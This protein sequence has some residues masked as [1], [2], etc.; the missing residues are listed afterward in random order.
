MPSDPQKANGEVN[1]TYTF[2]GW[3]NPGTTVIGDMEFVAVYK[4]EITS[5]EGANVKVDVTKKGCGQHA[6]DT[7][8]MIAGFAVIALLFKKMFA[9]A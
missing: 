1:V 2:N 3:S 4:M 8:G 6:M 9:K 5:T 7:I